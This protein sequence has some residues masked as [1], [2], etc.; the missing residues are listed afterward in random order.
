MLAAG[1]GRAT[2]LSQI[3]KQADVS[4]ATVLHHFASK[5]QLIS[6]A[7]DSSDA[8]YDPR[9]DRGGDVETQ[10]K[11]AARAF[12][13]QP[14]LVGMFT[15]LLTENIDPGAPLHERFLRRYRD[16]CAI[17]GSG[18]RRGQ[19]AG[20]FRPDVDPRVKARE[21]VA[22][23]YGIELAWLLDPDV[24]VAGVFA[25]YTRSLIEQL[26]DRSTPCSR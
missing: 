12:A 24:P 23:L 9:V 15:V 25:E 21:V 20:R 11:R 13:R 22:F 17:I 1:G 16:T 19:R 14:G 6:S 4:T 7:L 8:S 3:A 18:I 26:S 2:A 5:E 10:L